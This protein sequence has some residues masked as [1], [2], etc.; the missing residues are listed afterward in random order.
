MGIGAFD[1]ENFVF[2]EL[3]RE[4]ASRFCY[5]ESGIL[6]QVNGSRKYFL[7]N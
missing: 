5:P 2:K 7:L 4:R 3:F 1:R 6:K